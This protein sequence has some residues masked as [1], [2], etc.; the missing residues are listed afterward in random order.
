MWSTL[1]ELLLIR[2][3]PNFPLAEG[4]HII[5]VGLYWQV[6]MDDGDKEKAFSIGSGL[7]QF[8]VMQFR[9]C[10]APATFER[11]M[12]QVLSCLP[13]STALVYLDDFLVPAR[14]FADHISTTFPAVQAGAYLRSALYSRRK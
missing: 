11:L 10:N 3:V 9:R 12:E 4:V 1:S 8:T 7:W 14:T 13:L 6:E 2:T 5:E